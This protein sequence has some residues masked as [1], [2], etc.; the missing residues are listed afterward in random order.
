[1]AKESRVPALVEARF[2][3]SPFHPDEPTQSI[4]RIQDDLCTEAKWLER[5]ADHSPPTSAK[6]KHTW[7]Y[8]CCLIVFQNS[9]DTSNPGHHSLQI[10]VHAVI[11]Y[12]VFERYSL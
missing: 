2:F 1:M 9:M 4:Q 3:F 11:S 8:T 10:L 7:I 5:E 12:K 6:V